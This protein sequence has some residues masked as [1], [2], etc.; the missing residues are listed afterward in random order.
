[1]SHSE[2]APQ[3]DRASTSSW[4]PCTPGKHRR[5]LGHSG[6]CR[7]SPATGV[8]TTT[9]RRSLAPRPTRTPANCLPRSHR[10]WQ[11]LLS[12]RFCRKY[13]RDV[14]PTLNST[15]VGPGR[16]EASPVTLN[17]KAPFLSPTDS[18][19]NGPPRIWLPFGAPRGLRFSSSPPPTLNTL[20]CRELA[21]S[22]SRD[23]A[24]EL[25]TVP[26]RHGRCR[27]EHAAARPVSPGAAHGT[28]VAG[29]VPAL[30]AGP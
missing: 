29:L 26:P 16:P 3:G 24:A 1:M 21:P 28:H 2:G 23:T 19:R 14:G 15:C 20:E 11:R 8:P 5:S 9:V 18:R 27:W 17:E 4:A 6:P 22:V 7:P 10:L 12:G 25:G 30:P 13:V